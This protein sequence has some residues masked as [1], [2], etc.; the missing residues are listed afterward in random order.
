MKH[1]KNLHYLNFAGFTEILHPNVLMN[2]LLIFGKISMDKNLLLLELLK[3]KETSW[4]TVLKHAT[5]ELLISDSPNARLFWEL[6]TGLTVINKKLQ[7]P[8]EK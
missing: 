6:F 3:W 4:D 1:L 5:M 8:R 7:L 2:K